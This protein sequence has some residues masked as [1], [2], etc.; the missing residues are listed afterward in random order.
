MP[1]LLKAPTVILVDVVEC[2]LFYQFNMNPMKFLRAFLCSLVIGSSFGLVSCA[3]GPS[4]AEALKSLPPIPRDKGRIFVYRDS[5]FGA[6]VRPKININDKPIGT[7]VA[8]GFSYSDQAPGQ[9]V[10]SLTTEVKRQTTVTVKAGEPSFVHTYMTMGAIVG[11]VIPSFV[12][13]SQGESG[14]QKCKL[15]SP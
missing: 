3:S 8:K 7:S 11:H 2:H 10:V 9:Y 1:P 5:A 12:D 4:Y 13:K 14:I 15:V 6:A